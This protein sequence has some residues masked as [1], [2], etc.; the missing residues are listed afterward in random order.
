MTQFLI[1]DNKKLPQTT[2]TKL[3]NGAN[4]NKQTVRIMAELARQ[5]ASHPMVRQ[6]AMDIVHQANIPSHN[7]LDECKAIGAY[8]QKNIRYLKDPQGMEQLTDPVLLIKRIKEGTAQGDCDDMALLICTLLKS[9][10]HSPYLRFVKYKKLTGPYNHIYVVCYEKNYKGKK[11]RIA[12]DAIVK[13]KGMGYELP[14][15]FGSEVRV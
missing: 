14:H 3:A 8:V 9:I 6:L 4:G 11:E 5:R 15:A 2:E 1:K 13:D 7:Y 12:L 10:G